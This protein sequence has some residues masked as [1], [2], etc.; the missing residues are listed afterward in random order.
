MKGT[1]GAAVTDD[2]RLPAE[3]PWCSRA[4]PT[5]SRC[6]GAGSRPACRWSTSPSRPDTC[7]AAPSHTGTA[8]WTPADSLPSGRTEHVRTTVI[9]IIV[10]I[11]V[12]VI[13]IITIVGVVALFLFALF[14]T[15]T[16]QYSSSSP[17][18]SSFFL[19]FSFF[20]IFFLFF[21]STVFVS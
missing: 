14:F 17:S 20:F 12:V 11:T 6:P 10:I 18:P 4:F 9:I 3:P 2:A 21:Y 16:Y 19:S 1:T 13:V 8:P 7:C 5:G 15:Q